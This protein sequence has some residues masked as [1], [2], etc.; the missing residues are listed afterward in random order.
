[1]AELK[2]RKKYSELRLK[3]QALSHEGLCLS[4]A[5]VVLF[6]MDQANFVVQIPNLVFK[7]LG[8]PRHNGIETVET[9]LIAARTHAHGQGD[10][11]GPERQHQP[12]SVKEEGS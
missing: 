4:H 2:G 8:S 3:R 10:R 12:L 1:M 5:V 6:F 7:H 11:T 9:P